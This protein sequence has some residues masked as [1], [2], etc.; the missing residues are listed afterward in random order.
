MSTTQPLI[1]RI[2]EWRK[3]Y[4]AAQAADEAF[5]IA[6]E[7]QFSSSDDIGYIRYRTCKHN[8][9]TRQAG[10]AYEMACKALSNMN[11]FYRNNSAA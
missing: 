7:R 10:L 11:E 1:D 8:A 3:L 4:D 2:P 5:Q 6:L 9:E